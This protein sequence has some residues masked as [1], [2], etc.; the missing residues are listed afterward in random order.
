MR[1]KLLRRRLTVSAARVSVR[2]AMPW[3][4]RW[5]ALAAFIGLCAAVALWVFEFGK[6]IAGLDARSRD[7]LVQL[8]REVIRLREETRVRHDATSAEGSL[9]TAERAALERVMARTRQLEADNRTLRDDLGFFEKLIPA[10]KADGISI[11]GLQVEAIGA[12]QLRWQ[13]LVIQPVRN[14]PEFKG[15]MELQA[16]GTRDGKP[17][18][19]P[20]PGGSQALQFEHYRRVEGLSEIPANAVV[21]T[22]TARVLEGNAVRATHHFPMQ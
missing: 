12:G 13:I 14:A 9:L 22:V 2:S 11:R 3:P 1:L 20:L 4:L 8:R 5:M 16:E 7:E 6:S 18:T 15:R 21:K 10:G 19:Q 17:W